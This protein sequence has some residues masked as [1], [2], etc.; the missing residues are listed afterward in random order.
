LEAYSLLLDFA[1]RNHVEDFQ[2]P[3]DLVSFSA[4]L[5]ADVFNQFLNTPGKLSS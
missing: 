4:E 3:D 1:A 5:S 2:M